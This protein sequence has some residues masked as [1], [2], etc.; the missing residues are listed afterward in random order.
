MRRLRSWW[1]LIG[2]ALV[3]APTVHAQGSLFAGP[4]LVGP[5]VAATPAR[6][7]R[8][9]LYDISSDTRRDLTFGPGRH[10]VWD[11]SPDGCRVLFTLG[12]AL[13]LPGVYS[14]RID[15]A[16]VRPLLQYDELPPEAWGAWEPDWSPDGTKIA[17]TLVRET[18]FMSDIAREA[19][20][21]PR[22]YRVGWIPGAGG[23]ITFYSVSGDEHTPRWSPDGDWLAYVGYESRVA[24]ADYQSTAVPT[25]PAEPP[26]DLPEVNEADLWMVRADGTN[27]TRLTYFE[28]GSVSNPRWSPDGDLIGFVYSPLGNNDQ[29]WMVGSQAGATPTQLSFEW[30]L[31]LDLTWLPN[32]AAMLAAIRGFQQ[33]GE[34]RLWQIPLVGNADTEAS[35]YISDPALSYHDFPRFSADGRWLALRS[36]YALVL[37]DTLDQSWRILDDTPGNTPPVW[38]PPGFAG[39]VN[40]P[41]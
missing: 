39:E 1:V 12:D 38:S 25:Q 11:F 31:A 9:V 36:E 23:P 35:Q 3:V 37:L 19:E 6:Q 24:G 8:I 4:P 16:D 26:R 10:Q 21:D 7:D 40:C 20:D 28:T 17:L 27:K 29:F 13:G 32:G 18:A 22:E 33:V 2:A 5:V 30:Q 14:A 34:N 15:G 41:S